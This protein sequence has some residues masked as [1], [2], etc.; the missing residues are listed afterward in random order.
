MTKPYYLV[1]ILCLGLAACAAEFTDGSDSNHVTFLNSNGSSMAELTK[2]AQA[3]CQQY[4][5]VAS[6]R[7]SD[8]AL[9]AGFDCK[10]PR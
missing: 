5:K 3:Y 9:V 7:S 1:F 8:T 4:G 6:Y 2:K 10:L